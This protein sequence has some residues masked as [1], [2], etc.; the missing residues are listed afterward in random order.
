M[1]ALALGVLIIFYEMDSF[2]SIHYA[3]INYDIS[4]GWFNHLNLF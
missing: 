2:I 1:I 3:L 4:H